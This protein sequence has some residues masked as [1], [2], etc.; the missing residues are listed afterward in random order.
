VQRVVTKVDGSRGDRSSGESFRTLSVQEFD[1]NG[2]LLRIAGDTPEGKQGIRQSALTDSVGRVTGMESFDA[3]GMLQSRSTY[4]FDSAGNLIE[5]ELYDDAGVQQERTIFGYSA[6]GRRS[7]SST[8]NSAGV[9]TMRLTYS[10]D[11]LGRIVEITRLELSGSATQRYS[12]LRFEYDREG[13]LSVRRT[14]A[15]ALA[16]YASGEF[17]PREIR[18]EHYTYDSAGAL[19]SET[20]SDSLTGRTDQ[21]EYTVD[22]FGNWV[23]KRLYRST[24]QSGGG[25]PVARY[26]R[27][28][29]YFGAA[30]PVQ[31]LEGSAGYP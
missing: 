26:R 28:I 9:E 1:S 25:R 2:V 10:H 8:F 29:S 30:G 27:T 4:K 23:E 31:A 14:L 5:S 6:P 20:E 3:R 18:V 17:H 11:S 19:A 21:A 15:D 7:G 22:G 12:L 13:R 24:G 16:R